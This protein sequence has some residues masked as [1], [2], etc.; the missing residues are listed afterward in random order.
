MMLGLILAPREI[1]H[2][3]VPLFIG[4]GSFSAVNEQLDFNNFVSNVTLETS[5][6]AVVEP[7]LELELNVSK[8]V[9]LNF[10]ASYRLIQGSNLR[11]VTDSD[12][13]GFAG[14]VTVKIGKF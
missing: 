6:F 1:V 3:T 10:G 12:L 2:I 13:S 4:A 5:S 11:G 8:N 14:N 7:G 9:R